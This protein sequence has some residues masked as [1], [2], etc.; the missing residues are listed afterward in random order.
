MRW[1]LPLPIAIALVA[2]SPERVYLQVREPSRVGLEA[3]TPEGH[4]MILAP[5]A[6]AETRTFTSTSLP[7]RTGMN[8][9]RETSVERLPGGAIRIWGGDLLT[10]GGELRTFRKYGDACT[11]QGATTAQEPEFYG[12]YVRVSFCMAPWARQCIRLTLITPRDNIVRLDG[13]S[14]TEPS[15]SYCEP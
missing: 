6:A 8:P 10:R 3:D 4:V 11:R 12:E 13:P 9:R 1:V 2:C 7:Y 5:G 14:R 15:V